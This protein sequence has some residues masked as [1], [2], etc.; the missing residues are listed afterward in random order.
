MDFAR[1]SEWLY[2]TL[3]ASLLPGTLSGLFGMMILN[4]RL[5]LLSIGLYLTAIVAAVCA[6]VVGTHNASAITCESFDLCLST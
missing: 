3:Y 5:L 6:C 4:I 1:L 2:I